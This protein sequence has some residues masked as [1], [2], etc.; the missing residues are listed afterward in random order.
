MA[1]LETLIGQITA[2][3]PDDHEL[4]L[5]LEGIDYPLTDLAFHESGDLLA[6]TVYPGSPWAETHI[7][8][9]AQLK[10]TLHPR[11][12][13]ADSEVNAESPPPLPS[14]VIRLPVRP[15]LRLVRPPAS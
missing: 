9:K 5:E 10:L 12:I 2:S 4:T 15:R 3:L 6:I 13:H 8:N 1:T 7:L 11:A 14:P